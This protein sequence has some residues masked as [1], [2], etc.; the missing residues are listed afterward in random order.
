[1]EKERKKER[2]EKGKTRRVGPV[3]RRTTRKEE[4]A[5]AARR[6]I[7]EV[8]RPRSQSIH[9]VN[10]VR[11]GEDSSGYRR[12]SSDRYGRVAMVDP[13]LESALLPAWNPS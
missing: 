13:I 1:M 8:V 4:R 3:G 6:K 7:V 2:E 9:V 11:G 5:A 10:L 12:P